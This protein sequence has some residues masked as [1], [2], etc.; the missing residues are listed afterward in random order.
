MQTSLRQTSKVRLV[1]AGG[2]DREKK[3]IFH[4]KLTHARKKD[5]AKI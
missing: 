2:T 1:K 5:L 4:N 3:K